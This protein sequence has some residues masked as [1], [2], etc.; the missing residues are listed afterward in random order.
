MHCTFA[1]FFEL[2]ID[3]QTKGTDPWWP[4]DH[5]DQVLSTLEK[6]RNKCKKCL[7]VH[8]DRLRI[9]DPN[10][11]GPYMSMTESYWLH[12]EGLEIVEPKDLM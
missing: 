8:F 6:H 12:S 7:D 11:L 4:S 2:L 1:A 3:R 5:S 10:R 9:V